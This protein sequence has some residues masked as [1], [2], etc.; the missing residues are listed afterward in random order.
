MIAR[1]C[2]HTPRGYGIAYRNIFSATLVCY[3]VPLNLLVRWW[4]RLYRRLA[5]PTSDSLECQEQSALSES[6]QRGFLQGYKVGV[7]DGGKNVT[8][9]IVATVTTR[10]SKETL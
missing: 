7:S 2:D 1:E 3:P 8:E 6:F 5:K 9:A 10:C 4:H